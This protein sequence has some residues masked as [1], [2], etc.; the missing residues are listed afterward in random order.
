MSL[1]DTTPSTSK[2]LEGLNSKQREAV[3]HVAGPVLVIAGPGS[4]KTHTLVRRTLYLIEQN[5]AKP[6]QI[7]LCTFT[8]KAALELRDRV[9]NEA[10]KLGI[11][12]DM[13][14]LIVGTIHGIANDFLD[15]YRHKTPLGNNFTVLDDLTKSL[16]MNENFDALVEGFVSDSDDSGRERYFN[17]KWSTKWTA[18]KGLQDYFSRIAEE[19]L[20]ISKLKQSDNE[21]V[22]QIAESY[23]RY[24]ALLLEQNTVDFEHLQVFFYQLLADTTEGQQV[25]NSVKYVMV[26]EYQ[27][28][29]FVQEQLVLKLASASNNICVVGDEDQSLY[30]F[31]GATV[32]N[33]LE[34][35][36]RVKGCHEVTLN[37]NYRSHQKIV[38]AYDDYMKSHTWVD[39]NGRR[40]RFD[41]TIIADPDG[42]FPDY[43]AVVRI[44]G[45]SKSDE[46]QRLADFVKHLLD[47]GIVKDA[48]QVAL[49]LRSVKTEHSLPYIE[50]LRERGIKSFCPRARGFFQLDEIR[51]AVGVL[52]I[53]LEYIGANRSPNPRGALLELDNYV[54]SCLLDLD[55]IVD[56][57]PD[58]GRLIQKFNT[59]ISDLKPGQTLDRRVADYIYEFLA[60]SPFREM[61][62]DANQSRTLATFSQM[63]VTFQQF[64]GFTVV[65][66]RNVTALRRSLFSSFLR[67]LYESGIN[68]WEDPDQAFPKGH[69]PIMTIHQAKGLE[70]PVTV[71]G[72]L[73]V[74]SSSGKELDRNLGEFYNRPVFEPEAMITGFDR[75]R[76]HYVAYSRAEKILVLT[77]DTSVGTPS[78]PWH[79]P[80][81]DQA[82]DWGAE[83]GRQVETQ[84]W[85]ARAKLPPKKPYSFTGDLKAYETCPRQYQLYRLFEFEPSRAVLITFGLLVHQTIE[86]I[87]R[88]TL[89][90]RGAEVDAKFIADRFEFNYRHLMARA[91][92]KMAQ[93]QKE[94]ALQHV[95]RYWEQNQA[96]IARVQETEVDVSLEKDDYILHGAI[97]LVLGDA[98][99]LEVLDF[100]AQTRPS[101]EDTEVIR[102]YYKQLCIYAHI[103]EQ[104]KGITPTKL[105]IYWTGE[106]D[107]KRALMTFDYRRED[108]EEAARHFDDV[109][110]DIRAEK[111]KVVNVPDQKVCNECDFKPYCESVGT[112]QPTRRKRRRF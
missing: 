6:E 60:V 1:V 29:N 109:V 76:L 110:R 2:V 31:R 42:V 112:I 47:H 50:A 92:R 85:D 90:G 100:K 20:D 68:E 12:S 65:T 34:F 107:K 87:H 72:S 44:S 84:S 61:I 99:T 33:I 82:K 70:F 96:E 62:G 67:L 40:F 94:A 32:R 75:M 25:L 66:S 57:N 49:L 7:V 15:K 86:D 74:S 106:T 24:R 93:E 19:M 35:P 91:T 9:R 64:Y 104:R 18:I 38:R 3:T 5:L 37:V 88:L 51:L 27:D 103:L 16:F 56:A 78:Q 79:K 80:I 54:D 10:A 89:E 77:A 48:S 111:F 14:G 108:V 46:A 55:P 36:N 23:E 73:Q 11:T 8:E 97:D 71:V 69:V 22:A 63:L 4:G 43:P 53:I 52:A 105:H 81:W 101:D 26:D 59:E 39:A 41:K 95:M 17:E 98:G 83:A 21:L 28:T 45:T 13:S 58:L 30:R 102:T